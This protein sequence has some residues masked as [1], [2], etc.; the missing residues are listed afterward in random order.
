M[1]LE[2]YLIATLTLPGQ[3]AAIALAAALFAMFVVGWYVL[4][5]FARVR[6]G[7]RHS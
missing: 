7:R 3:G 4:P 6:N 1:S 5:A 2:L